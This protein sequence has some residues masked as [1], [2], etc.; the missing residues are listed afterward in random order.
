MKWQGVTSIPDG[1]HEIGFS[2]SVGSNDGR[3]GQ[4]GSEP[5]KAFVRLEVFKLDILELRRR[6]HDEV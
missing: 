5:S 4:H 3:E 1:V 2:R 6:R